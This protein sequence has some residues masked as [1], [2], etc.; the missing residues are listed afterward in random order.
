MNQL[1]KAIDRLIEDIGRVM[2]KEK[3]E[4]RK[5]GNET[6]NNTVNIITANKLR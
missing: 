6:F 1:N 3:K 4:R 2:A 5:G